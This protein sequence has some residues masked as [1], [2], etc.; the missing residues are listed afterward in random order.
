MNSFEQAK[1]TITQAAE[2]AGLSPSVLEQLLHPQ[3]EVSVNF[4]ITRDSGETELIEGYRVQHNNWRGPYKGG[5]RFHQSVDIDEVRALAAWMSIKTAVVNIPLGG[6]KGG[7]VIDPK[8]YSEKELEQV[9]RGWTR[10]MRGVIGPDIDIPAPD[11]NTS[12]RE[13]AWMADAFGDPAVTTGKPLDKGGSEG[14]NTATAQGGV[15]VLESILESL[16]RKGLQ[17]IAIEGFGNAGRIFAELAEGRGFTVV[18]VSDSRGAIYAE[19]GLDVSKLISHKESTGA[20]QGFEGASDISHDELFAVE[21]DIF[22]PAALDG[23]VTLKRAES[24][25]AKVVLELANGPLTSEGEAALLEQSV[26]IIPDILANAGGVTVSY[27]EWLQNKAGEHWSLEEVDS[28]LQNI[29]RTA[30][31]EVAEASSRHNLSLRHAAYVMAL[32]RLAESRY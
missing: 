6:G 30:A 23:S 31:S 24:M 19:Q 4:P 28:R 26:L 14:R 15:Y 3:R 1:Q 5:L 11:V 10:A 13:M 18:A 9:M 20:V 29:M 25:K 12:P 22:V 27:F 16:D 32:R 7:V 17:T 8:Q 2:L 21:A